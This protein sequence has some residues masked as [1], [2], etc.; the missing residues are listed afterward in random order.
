MS[1]S[2]QQ[3][4]TT[5]LGVYAKRVALFAAVSI[6]AGCAPD[7]ASNVAACQKETLRF[8]SDSTGDDFMIACMD[9]KGYRFDVEPT[10]CDS[11][12]RMARQS[13]CYVP[14]GWLAEFLDGLARP[15][16]K[17]APAAEVKSDR[18]ESKPPR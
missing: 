2:R 7:K 16:A 6:I 13:S 8:Y 3:T 14:E 5:P 4:P 12:S 15:P 1:S 10:D 18:P 17:P 9:A 11:K